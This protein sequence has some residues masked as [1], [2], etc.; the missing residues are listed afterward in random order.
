MLMPV[1]R[2]P[3][4]DPNGPDLGVPPRLSRATLTLQCA[5]ATAARLRSEPDPTTSSTNATRSSG[6]RTAICLL[7]PLMVPDRIGLELVVMPT[8]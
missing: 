1:L 6:R 5:W 4:L 8:V 7:I 3:D 2:T